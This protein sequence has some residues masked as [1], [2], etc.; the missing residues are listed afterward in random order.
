MLCLPRDNAVVE[1]IDSRVRLSGFG[2]N[3]AI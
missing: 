2:F 1:T 3:S